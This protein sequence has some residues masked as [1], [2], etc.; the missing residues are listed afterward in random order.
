LANYVKLFNKTNV[1]IGLKM[2][3]NRT[4]RN[5][6]WIFT[7]VSYHYKTMC[8]YRSTLVVY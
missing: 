5:T 3:D 8:I 2:F 4:V 7:E 1:L 6:Y